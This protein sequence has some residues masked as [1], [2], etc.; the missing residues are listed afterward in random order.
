[1]SGPLDL[2]E[3]GDLTHPG[4]AVYGY[5]PENAAEFANWAAK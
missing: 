2:D 3:N 4:F 1:V 5:T